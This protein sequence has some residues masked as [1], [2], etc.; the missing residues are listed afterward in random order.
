M[1]RDQVFTVY[2]HHEGILIPSP[3]RYVQGDEKQITDID[4]EGMKFANLIDII[5]HL[6][7]GIVY[8]NWIVYPSG[9]EELEAGCGD[10]AYGVNLSLRK[11][12]CRFWQLSGVPCIHDVAGKR[13]SICSRGGGRGAES[14]GTES[15]GRGYMG[16]GRCTISGGRETMVGARGRRGGARGRIGGAKGRIC[17]GRG[18]TSGLNL[19]DEDDIRQSMEHEYLQGLLD[20][21]EDLRKKK[22]KEHQEKL[23][24]EAFQQA[25]KEEK[26]IDVEMYNGNKASINFMVNTQESVTHG[27]PSSVKAASVQPAESVPAFA[28]GLS[29]QVAK[30]VNV[31]P[32]S[33]NAA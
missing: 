30:A 26:S 25:M 12:V 15:G 4:F 1:V 31:Q 28:E 11:C 13:W 23:D 24:E 8:R 5:K 3:L 29:V 33:D 27:Q 18:S 19:M 16:C 17:G 9:Y 7:H 6:V 14:G 32:V 2:L 10:Q 21:Q 22:E 20:E